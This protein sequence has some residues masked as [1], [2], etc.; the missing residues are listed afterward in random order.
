MP[1]EEIYGIPILMKKEE[2]KIC[3]II[4]QK[5]AEPISIKTSL[6]SRIFGIPNEVVFYRTFLP[7]SYYSKH[8]SGYELKKCQVYYVYPIKDKNNNDGIVFDQNGNL[9][10]Q[11]IDNNLERELQIILKTY[12]KNKKDMKTS[13]IKKIKELRFPKDIIILT[14]K[15]QNNGF[16]YVD[17]LD[18]KIKVQ[19]DKEGHKLLFKHFTEDTLIT[20]PF[21]VIVLPTNFPTKIIIN[22][23]KLTVN[24]EPCVIVGINFAEYSCEDKYQ[25]ESGELRYPIWRVDSTFLQEGGMQKMSSHIK[26][27]KFATMPNGHVYRLYYLNKKWWV[28]ARVKGSKRPQDI[29]YVHVV[30]A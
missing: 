15:S 24:D 29:R 16:I 17:N 6:F 12:V 26:T 2:D 22:F 5:Y 20:K 19:F 9:I 21:F 10:K 8:I 25:N 11:N 30:K 28:K 18:D 4:P 3:G 23:N 7:S 27:R 13:L 14:E 1:K